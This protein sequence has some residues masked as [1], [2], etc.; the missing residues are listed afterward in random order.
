MRRL[1]KRDLLK[2]PDDFEGNIR[3]PLAAPPA[4]HGIVGSRK[5]APKVKMMP[6]QKGKPERPK[7]AGT[8]AYE[9]AP[10]SKAGKRKRH[11]R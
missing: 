1:S 3:A 11:A 10:A 9:S 5:A 6:C 8:Y 4:P 2:L 7:K